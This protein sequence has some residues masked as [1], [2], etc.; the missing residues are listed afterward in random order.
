M[1]RLLEGV[2]PAFLVAILSSG[3]AQAQLG[4]R[5][6][7]W[8]APESAIRSTGSHPLGIESDIGLGGT[9]LVPVTPCRIVDTRGAVGPFG[10]PSLSPGSPRNF[11][12]LSGPCTG[13]PGAV[14]AYSLNITATNTQGGGFFKVYPQGGAAPVVSTLNYIAGQTVAN[15]AIVPAGTG[16]GITVAAGVAG[17]DL[18]IDINGYF[19]G[20]GGIAPLNPNEFVGFKGSYPSGPV[21]FGWNVNS[22]GYGVWGQGAGIGV[23]GNSLSPSFSISLA[24][25]W[26]TSVNAIGTFGHSDN[27]NGMWAESTTYD[28]LATFG[29][30]DGTYSQGARYGVVGVS[31]GTANELAGV[32]GISNSG[33]VVETFNYVGAG[34]RGEGK[35][36]I[37]VLGLT[38]SGVGV[39]GAL[40]NSASPATFVSEGTLGNGTYGVYAFGDTGATG[41]KSFVEPY[42]LDASKVIRYVSLEGPES[43]TYF[44]GSA[45]IIHG[46]AVI[47]VP[48]DFRMVTDSEGL[49]VQLTPV[50]APARMYVISEDLGEIVVSAD[51]DVKFHYMING[52]RKAF[53]DFQAVGE[54]TEFMPRSSSEKM[55]GYLTAEA[56]R[57]LIANGTYNADGTVNMETA[58]RLGW[59]RVWQERE[60]EARAS[61]HQ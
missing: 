18:L 16:G 15:A 45:Q 35:A 40:F 38:N 19:V 28:A 3:S 56:K 13:L 8:S 1:K 44:R 20:N 10:A 58:Q 32:R 25:V 11:A 51:R 22:T 14:L 55:P 41:V 42:E 6:P 53:K 4:A 46:R 27:S 48:E 2:F 59:A 21:L 31:T 23:Y 43:G 17:A 37:G 49:T 24:G 60:E 54:G 34:V 7:N 50:G 12:L 61:A 47:S 5:V 36:Q 39:I 29:G 9:A 26:G 33:A 57:R 30:R 52:V